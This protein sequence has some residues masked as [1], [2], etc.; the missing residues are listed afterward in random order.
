MGGSELGA[1]A[2]SGGW[3]GVGA[4]GGGNRMWLAEGGE[5]L[6]PKPGE[7]YPAPPFC[8]PLP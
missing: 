1:R 4:V 6:C 2:R 3:A 5:E 8:H 7:R